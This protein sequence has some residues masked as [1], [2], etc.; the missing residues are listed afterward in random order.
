M[1]ASHNN[2]NSGYDPMTKLV[3]LCIDD[4][5]KRDHEVGFHAGYYTFNNMECFLK[6]KAYMDAALGKTRYGGRQHFLRFSA[7][8]TWRIWEAADLCYD[9]TLSYAD[10]EGFRCGTCHPFHPFDIEK[11]RQMNILEIPLIVMDGTLRQYRNLSII[12]SEKQILLL[13]QRCKMVNGV[14]T[15]LWH[16]SSLNN[17][18]ELWASMYQNVLSELSRIS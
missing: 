18:W 11:N 2:Y 4:L 7:P 5:R 8:E 15:I 1:S 3:Q 6:E 13:A 17:D 10:H 14:F 9:S 12:E 16:N